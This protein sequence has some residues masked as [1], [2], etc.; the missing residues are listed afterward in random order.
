MDSTARATVTLLPS[1]ASVVQSSS[2]QNVHQTP[3]SSF[4]PSFATSLNNSLPAAFQVNPLLLLQDVPHFNSATASL[5]DLLEWE[6]RLRDFKAT[7]LLW[8]PV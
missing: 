6:Q 2:L 7:Y 4:S 1:I 5:D 8:H 3:L